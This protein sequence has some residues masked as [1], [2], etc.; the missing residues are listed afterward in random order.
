MPNIR[1]IQDFFGSRA[2]GWEQ[3]FPKD[4]SQLAW[5]DDTED[6]YL[7]IARR[8]PAEIVMP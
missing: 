4:D 6:C 3:K 7:A 2:A 1:E 5:M 8:L